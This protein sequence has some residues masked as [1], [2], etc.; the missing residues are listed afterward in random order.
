M[1]QA[2]PA[3]LDLAM[4]APAGQREG[5]SCPAASSCGGSSAVPAVPA[6]SVIVPT[7][8]EQGNVADM[9]EALAGTLAG[10]PFEVIFVDDNSPD[11]TAQAV[12]QRMRR[13]KRARKS[14]SWRAWR[15]LRSPPLR[16]AEGT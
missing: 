14:L 16:C 4:E 12:R 15:T 11:G 5:R 6:L 13:R 10:V 7:F 9:F 8:N 3:L 1:L 2:S